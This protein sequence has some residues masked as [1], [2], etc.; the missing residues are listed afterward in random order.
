MS[1]QDTTDQSSINDYHLAKMIAWVEDLENFTTEQ[2]ER[3]IAL[4]RRRQEALDNPNYQAA[5]LKAEEKYSWAYIILAGPQG[6]FIN[7]RRILQIEMVLDEVD[8]Y[9]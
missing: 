3:A 9:L 2:K 6:F 8:K 1:I 4:L 5:L 7:E